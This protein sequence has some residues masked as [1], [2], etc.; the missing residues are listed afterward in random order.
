M[1]DFKP[2]EVDLNACFPPLANTWG[3]AEREV[4]ATLIVRVCQL[5]GDAWQ[6]V[7][8]KEIGETWKADRE[9]KIEPLASLATN[10]FWRPDIFDCVKHGFARWI[11][12]DDGKGPVELTE[13]GLEALR[14]WVRR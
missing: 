5:K 2:S 3:R 12:T 7:M 10:P 14:R 6:A 4:A 13:K 9:A 8:P 1:I 11:E